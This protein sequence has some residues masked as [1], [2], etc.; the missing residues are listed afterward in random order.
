MKIVDR[1]K[2]MEMPA[3]WGRDGMYSDTDRFMV[4]EPKDLD[5]LM[6][7]CFNAILV[8]KNLGEEK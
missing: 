6:Q 2:L 8:W 3:G 4:F 5:I 1:H 7:F